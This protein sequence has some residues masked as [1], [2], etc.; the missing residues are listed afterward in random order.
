MDGI[1]LRV[2]RFHKRY[3]SF[4]ESDPLSNCLGL[5]I[6]KEIPAD[7]AK[8]Q[9]WLAAQRESAKEW[10]LLYEDFLS[11]K[12]GN[13]FRT[14][15]PDFM[16]KR[17][18]SLFAPLQEGRIERVYTVD[19]DRE[20]FSVNN[21]DHF[22]LEQVPHI[23]WIDANYDESLVHQISLEDTVP[24]EGFTDSVIEQ[25]TQSGGS[26]LNNLTIG[27]VSSLSVTAYV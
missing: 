22:K 6:T 14:D 12:P 15:L 4:I 25:L 20:I 17:L 11:V 10:E 8:Y 1:G 27:D 5:Q 9:N 2:I 21:E 23:Q 19:L 7:A 3:Y 18:P 16:M 24:M 13:E 26:S